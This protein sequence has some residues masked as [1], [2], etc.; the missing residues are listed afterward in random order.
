M[1]DTDAAV[2][3]DEGM[4]M[5]HPGLPLEWMQAAALAMGALALW[6]LIAPL[7]AGAARTGKLG[8]AS[9]G[10]RVLHAVLGHR[11]PLLALRVASAALFVL[12]V[13]AGFFGSDIPERNAATVLVWNLWWPLV[14]LAVLFAGTAWCAIC[15][16]DALAGWLV[17][18]RLWRRVVPPPGLHRRVPRALRNVWLALALFLLLTW[19]EIGFGVTARPA[20]TAALALVLLVL[21]TAFLLLYERKAFCR[22][23]CP[24]G[25]TLGCYSRL[26]AVAVRPVTQAVCDGCR[27]LECFNGSREIEPCPTHLTVG[28]FS[29]NT[30]CLSCGNCVQ[31]CPHGN[32]TWRLRSPAAE[33]RELARP[34]ADVAWFMLALLGVTGFH[35]LTMLPQWGEWTAD[36]VQVLGGRGQRLAIFTLGMAVAVALPAA[37]YAAAVAL[38]RLTG[39]HAVPYRELFARYAFVALPLAF[40]YHLA[41]NFGHLARE[42]VELGALFANPLGRGLAPRTMAEVHE[43]M[44]DPLLPDAALFSLQ[45][46]LLVGGCWLALYVLRHQAVVTGGGLRGE[47]RGWRLWPL[48][49]FALAA[50]ACSLWLMG[51]DMEMRF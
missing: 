50:S 22:Y 16:W 27:T 34:P 23:A 41:H 12:V 39:A 33:A 10:G 37:L 25:R 40:A 48:A 36:V 26:A 1:A 43:R 15:P 28:R 32:V 24:V 29:E 14:V 17:R 7:P 49:G 45:A 35:G 44:A 13:V 30:F 51:Q 4:I 20:V 21:A 6:S 9:V 5:L 3:A 2:P 47:M 46:A 11:A 42:S 31:S 8:F 18:R 19:L 38:T